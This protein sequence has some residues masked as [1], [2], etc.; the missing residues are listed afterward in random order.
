VAEVNQGVRGRLLLDAHGVEEDA[1]PA[2]AGPEPNGDGEAAA[3]RRSGRR[4][5]AAE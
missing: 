1:P 5:A 2:L 3:G 4:R